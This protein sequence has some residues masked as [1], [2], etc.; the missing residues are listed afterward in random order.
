MRVKSCL[1]RWLVVLGICQAATIW[2][3]RPRGTE[4]QR[5]R[6]TEAQRQERFQRLKLYEFGRQ[7]RDW[8]A[9]EAEMRHPMLRVR[10]G[11]EK[12]LTLILMARS[13]SVDARILACRG[14][15][16]VGGKEGI[17]ALMAHI[18]DQRLSAE[19][20]MALQ[21]KDSGEINPALREAL[22]IVGNALKT[23][24]I[25]T[26]GR[27]GDRQAVPG[28]IALAKEIDD[29]AI[30]QT[31]IRALGQIGGASAVE[32]LSGTDLGEAYDGQREYA[33][34]AAAARSM[35]LGPTDRE[36]GLAAL[37]KLSAESPMAMVR[38]GALYEWALH[39]GRQQLTLCREVLSGGREGMLDIAPRLFSL[40]ELGER[41]ALYGPFFDG[42]DLAAQIL[43]VEL[44]SSDLRHEDR[45]RAL[46]LSLSLDDGLRMAALR[47]VDRIEE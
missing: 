5:P 12:I 1:L 38:M 32:F 11:A 4:A 22:P 2:A 39:D 29:L 21:E 9:L 25:A 18:R 43:L 26:L 40:L 36:A 30:R 31:S 17:P 3:Q 15:R 7:R 34:L 33:L 37:E 10:V 47:A 8:N 27:R 28:I 23:H 42:L 19:A 6:E 41:N 45:V 14:L 24:I 46:S 44:W 35:G 13:S 16:L 20:C